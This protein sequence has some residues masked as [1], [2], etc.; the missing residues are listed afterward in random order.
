MKKLN[1][2]GDTI[3]EVMLAV[4]IL[5]MTIGVA[6]AVVNRSIKRAQQAQER[7]QATKLV[8]GQIDKLKYLSE[9]AIAEDQAEFIKA[10]DTSRGSQC[11]STKTTN[12]V[13]VIEAIQ[14]SGPFGSDCTQEN[15]FKISYLYDGND[16]IF[17][18]NANW[19]SLVSDAS[20]NV[21]MEYRVV[22]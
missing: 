16:K 3:V 19:D 4:A 7:T 1:Q 15:I 10:I 20:E 12:D 18:V 21:T 5:A 22:Q 9:S 13:T 8:E 2:I 6:Y 11:I 17:T 14:I